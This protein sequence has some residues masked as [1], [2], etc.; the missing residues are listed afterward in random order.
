VEASLQHE[1][2]AYANG[3]TTFVLLLKLSRQFVISDIRYM[4]TGPVVRDSPILQRP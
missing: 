2:K 3:V 4:Q 1:A